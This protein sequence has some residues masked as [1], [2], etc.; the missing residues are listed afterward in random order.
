MLN[1]RLV[2]GILCLVVG[3]DDDGSASVGASLMLDVIGRRDHRAGYERS[4]MEG[5]EAKNAV[6]RACYVRVAAAEAE[7]HSRTGIK[8]HHRNAIVRRENIQSLLRRVCDPLDVRLHASADI[9]EQ[10]NIDG[11]VFTRK[12]ANGDRLTVQP[13]DKVAF[14]EAS[15]DVAVR[16]DNLGVHARHRYIA[17][18]NYGIVGGT[19]RPCRRTQGRKSDETVHKTAY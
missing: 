13:E 4:A 2:F 9:D 15:D 6:K 10:K 16:I 18:E 17:L 7:F 11:H 12:V 19:K 1:S 3:E 5:L 8:D 14:T